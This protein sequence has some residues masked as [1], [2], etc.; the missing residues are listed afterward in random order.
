MIELVNHVVRSPAV[1][2]ERT[3]G[4]MSDNGKVSSLRRLPNY[5]ISH[6]HG[7]MGKLFYAWSSLIG[8]LCDLLR[9]I[10]EGLVVE[11]VYDTFLSFAKLSK[12]N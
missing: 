1:Q 3:L 4:I 10:L 9:H 7:K 11:R 6:A 12:I 2:P 5:N 8:L